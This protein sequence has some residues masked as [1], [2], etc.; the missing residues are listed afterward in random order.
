MISWKELSKY[1]CFE[2]VERIAWRK[3]RIEWTKADIDIMEE[4]LMANLDKEFGVSLTKLFMRTSVLVKTVEE[5]KKRTY[6][7]SELIAAMYKKLGLI[8]Q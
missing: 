3:L 2:Y 7:C 4:F 8:D 6:F 5:E 1:G